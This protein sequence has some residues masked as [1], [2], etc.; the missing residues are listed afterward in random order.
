[1]HN[2]KTLSGPKVWATCLQARM[3]A[4]VEEIRKQIR[5]EVMHEILE[6]PAYTVL[7]TACMLRFCRVSAL[8]TS[9]VATQ[10][11]WSARVSCQCGSQKGYLMQTGWMYKLGPVL[12]CSRDISV[13]MCCAEWTRRVKLI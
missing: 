13:S 8:C 9:V 11:A 7:P 5:V 6:D 2:E 10:I 1:M 12:L 3:E 4:E